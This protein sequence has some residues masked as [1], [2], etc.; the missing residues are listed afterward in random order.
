V[1]GGLFEAKQL[2]ADSL[3]ATSSAFLTSNIKDLT[4]DTIRAQAIEIASKSVDLI[5]MDQELASISAKMEI[6][7]ALGLFDGSQATNSGELVLFDN[8]MVSGSTTLSDAAVLNALL[9]GD[10]LTIGSNSI[11]TLGVDLE[12]QPLGQGG[13]RFLGGA[14]TIDTDGKLKVEED[15][16]F[17]KNVSVGGVLSA[18]DVAVSR[19]NVE[20]L[21][22][23]E[24]VAS[25]SS[26]LVTLP[27]NEPE[28]KINSDR[29]KASSLIFITPKGETST[30]LYIKEQN[31]GYF[32]VGIKEEQL[33]DIKFNFLI[34]N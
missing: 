17:A 23:T 18:K 4:V 21:S 7:Q 16:E 15:A 30:P 27:A 19:A 6:L 26:G 25:G 14:V 20:I 12:I 10:Y 1:T 3:N 9:V 13:V 11:D 34:V 22:E 31:E 5:K 33:V 8:L 28:L 32:V 24:V 2:N 29:A